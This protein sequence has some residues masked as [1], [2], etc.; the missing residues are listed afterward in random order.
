MRQNVVEANRERDL[1]LTDRRHVY[2]I[3]QGW[4]DEWSVAAGF[5]GGLDWVENGEPSPEINCY[6]PTHTKM[7]SPVDTLFVKVADLQKLDE[8]DEM[9]AKKLHPELFAHLERINAEA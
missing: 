5:E 9:P 1:L 7:N 4:C 8:I 3:P 6:A 2:F